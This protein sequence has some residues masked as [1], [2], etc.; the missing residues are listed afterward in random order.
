MNTIPAHA[1]AQTLDVEW[2]A[3]SGGELEGQR[4]RALCPGCREKLNRAANTRLITYWGLGALRQ[5]GAD[6][7]TWAGRS[8]ASPSR[9][10]PPLCFQCYRVGLVRDRALKAAGELD[11]A[12]DERFQGALPLEPVNRARLARL[13]LERRTARLASQSGSGRFVDRRRLAQIAARHALHRLANGLRARA[14]AKQPVAGSVSTHAAQLRLPASWLP[15]V[16][17]RSYPFSVRY[18]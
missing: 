8:G 15:F 18:R 5:G 13:K 4:P 17:S 11:T 1:A 7:N 16:A 12:S 14:V 9:P 2:V 3:F 10:S 6:P